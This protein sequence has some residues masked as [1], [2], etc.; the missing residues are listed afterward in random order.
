MLSATD[1]THL[2]KQ[3]VQSVDKSTPTAGMKFSDKHYIF[4]QD[5]APCHKAKLTKEFL[6]N[7]GIQVM[8]WPPY[9]PDPIENLWAT[10]KQKLSQGYSN[11]NELITNADRIW[12]EDCDIQ[13]HC[14]TLS[15]SMSNLIRK[16]IRNKGGPIN[17]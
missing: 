3:H 4:Q 9:F 14:R 10:L 13:R 12:M 16:C 17:Y 5:N 8:E 15:D 1:L 2:F 11:R 7:N 6:Q